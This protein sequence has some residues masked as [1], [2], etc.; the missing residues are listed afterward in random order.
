MT[1]GKHVSK[2]KGRLEKVFELL[3]LW[4][5]YVEV[6]YSTDHEIEQAISQLNLTSDM[7]KQ[8]IKNAAEE[9]SFQ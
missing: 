2:I 1:P 8:G 5:Q 7:A 4:Q 3:N 9:Q 6:I